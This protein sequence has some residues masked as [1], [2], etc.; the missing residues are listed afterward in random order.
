MLEKSGSLP[1][2]SKALENNTDQLIWQTV[3]YSLSH[4]ENQKPTFSPYIGGAR[5]IKAKSIFM[6]P[7][8][9]ISKCKNGYKVDMNGKCVEI[10]SINQEEILVN[11]LQ[12]LYPFHTE[13]IS[14]DYENSLEN[15]DIITQHE[16]PIMVENFNKTQVDE[17]LLSLADNISLAE[18]KMQK[19]SFIYKETYNMD[20]TL[21]NDDSIIIKTNQPV[22]TENNFAIFDTTSLYLNEGDTEG[23]KTSSNFL[24][25]Y[26]IS[27]IK[28][29]IKYAKIE[30]RL[31]T[32]SSDTKG[33]ETTTINME[34]TESANINSILVNDSLIVFE[35]NFIENNTDLDYDITTISN[36]EI[37]STSN[38]NEMIFKESNVSSVE[39]KTNFLFIPDEENLETSEDHS[40]SF[41]QFEIH[42]YNDETAN[43]K[44][45]DD[46]F[47][48]FRLFETTTIFPSKIIKSSENIKNNNLRF[49]S[50]EKFKNRLVNIR[51]P[52]WP[53]FNRFRSADLIQYWKAQPLINDCKYS[54]KEVTIDK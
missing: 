17:I 53:K 37:L 47:N 2:K 27:N 26:D 38:E 48:E 23:I 31:T 41:D 14:N 29:E 10:V 6:T 44:S 22:F 34:T 4:N 15:E 52:T 49:S 39:F 42:K 32:T 13:D 16:S 11:R 1:I 5:K 7:N 18:D 35:H 46:S 45:N 43:D 51:V 21:Q 19:E 8:L 50:F 25:L 3:W 24:D 12:N 20:S 36:L 54:S 40:D 30:N 9:N 33:E 28:E